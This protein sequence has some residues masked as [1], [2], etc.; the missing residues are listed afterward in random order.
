VCL[1]WLAGATGMNI[2]A[3]TPCILPLNCGEYNKSKV[4][5]HTFAGC[6]VCDTW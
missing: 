4:C 1:A 2:D 6:N 5:N 3:L